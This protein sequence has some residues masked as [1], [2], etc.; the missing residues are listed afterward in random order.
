MLKVVKLVQ[1]EKSFSLSASKRCKINIKM[2]SVFLASGDLLPCLSSVLS[3]YRSKGI[4][5]CHK[6]VHAGS[7]NFL[8]LVPPDRV[9]SVA[10]YF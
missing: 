6:S 1:I 4:L 2:L 7:I 8:I 5:R 3:C 10:A 9:A